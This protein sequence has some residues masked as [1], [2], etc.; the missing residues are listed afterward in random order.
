[1][2]RKSGFSAHVVHYAPVLIKS[3]HTSGR[4]RLPAALAAAVCLGLSIF[5]VSSCMGPIFR[6]STSTGTGT[7]Q[8]VAD[9]T[10][11]FTRQTPEGSCLWLMN[12][13][14][15]DTG[16]LTGTTCF[17]R[18]PSWANDGS[19]VVF[20]SGR[21]GGDPAIWCLDMNRATAWALAPSITGTCF[22][23]S[24]SPDAKHILYTNRSA[25][26]FADS[27]WVMDL[28]NEQGLNN[29][30]IIADLNDYSWPDWLD[31]SRFIVSRFGPQGSGAEH[32]ETGSGSI[33]IY[34]WSPVEEENSSSPWHIRSTHARVSKDGK[35]I[36]FASNKNAAQ[37]G[38]TMDIRIMNSDGSSPYEVLSD[39]FENIDPCWAMD[40]TRIVFSSNRQ[41]TWSLWMISPQGLDLERLT[42]DSASDFHADWTA[43]DVIF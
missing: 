42:D 26:D 36:V 21:T 27:L 38:N 15:M 9:G 18:M 28:Q 23:P 22:Y 25:S 43:R 4:F 17:D 41:G 3:W 1:M 19:F 29:R 32:G 12:P 31:D 10:L 14:T 6:D 2:K 39:N 34:G 40:D 35:R 8:A 16:P 33:T 30:R 13:A 24:V 7:G 37:N 11:V 5:A 20:S